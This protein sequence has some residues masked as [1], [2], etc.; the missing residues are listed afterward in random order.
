MNQP[1]QRMRVAA[2]SHQG[3]VRENNEDRV[4][5]DAAM[6]IAVLADG[7][8]GLNAG[9]IASMEAVDAVMMHLRGHAANLAEDPAGVLEAAVQR[10][11]RAIH[12]LA[13]TRRE[14]AGM[15]T[16][17]VVAALTGDELVTAH[18]GDSRAYCYEVG[19]L[20]RITTDHS[21][22]QQLVASGVLS[23]EQARRAPNRNI[24]TRALGVG[25]DIECDINR[26]PF[27]P[28]A[29]A[30]LCS[31][32]LTDMLDDATIAAVCAEHDTIADRVRTLLAG[33]LTA[34]GFDN[35]SIV[36]FER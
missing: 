21:L 20:T 32:G 22:V 34:G 15:G 28:G 19:G 2:V 17:L 35:V 18:V 25:R 9:E 14:Y 16:T 30:L 6:G 26:V 10:A 36:A 29:M 1:V 11:N 12:R 5:H 27:G 31:D 33:A 4:E 24:V 13:S 23:A 8:G 3:L 7:M